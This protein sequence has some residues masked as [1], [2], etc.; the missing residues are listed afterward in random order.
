MLSRVRLLQNFHRLIKKKKKL[1]ASKFALMGFGV[2]ILKVEFKAIRKTFM[3]FK[4]WSAL[5]EKPSV[6]CSDR[7]HS[8]NCCETKSI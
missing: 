1:A 3:F 4:C 5:E 2:Y 8:Y 7:I 6:G